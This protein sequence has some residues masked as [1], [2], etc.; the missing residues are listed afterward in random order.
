MTE[1]SNSGVSREKAQINKQ[2]LSHESPHLLTSIFCPT[3]LKCSNRI[4]YAVCSF[5]LFVSDLI[6]TGKGK[7]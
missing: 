7:R 6:L 4:V 2:D 5:A 3:I 1:L